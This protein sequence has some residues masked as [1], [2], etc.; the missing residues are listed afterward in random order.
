MSKVAD[1]LGLTIA[2]LLMTAAV[3]TFVATRCGWR[4]DAVLSGSMEPG[5]EEGSIAI[6]RPV[7]AEEIGT[8]DIVTFRSPMSGLPIAHRVVATENGSSFRTKG[9]AN[10][11]ADPLAVPAQD[12]IGKVCFHIPFLGYVATFVKTPFG[13]MLACL[14]GF[15]IAVDEIRNLLRTQGRA[16]AEGQDYPRG[17]HRHRRCL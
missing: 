13:I 2:I 17:W 6:T 10:E 9:D 16:R 1:H 12:I 11:C 4:V 3:L 14:L 5:L 8:G 7:P 15:L